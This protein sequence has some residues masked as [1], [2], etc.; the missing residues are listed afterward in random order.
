MIFG[1][2]DAVGYGRVTPGSIT[3]VFGD[4]VARTVAVAPEDAPSRPVPRRLNRSSTSS[5]E[6]GRSL[7]RL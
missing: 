5:A 7:D 3:I 4:T 2:L 1:G 6:V